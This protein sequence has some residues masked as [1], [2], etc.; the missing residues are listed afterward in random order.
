MGDFGMAVSQRGFDVKNCPDNKLLFSTQHRTLKILKEGWGNFNAVV[1]FVDGFEAD[2]E[3]EMEVIHDLGF[4]PMYFVFVLGEDGF[5]HVYYSHCT[6]T[7]LIVDFGGNM[8]LT[9]GQ[10][11]TVPLRYH[12]MIFDVDLEQSFE[13]LYGDPYVPFPPREGRRDYGVKVSAE[14]HNVDNLRENFNSLAS[15]GQSFSVHKQGNVVVSGSTPGTPFPIYIGH[16]LPYPPE[17]Y[18]YHKGRYADGGYEFVY[19]SDVDFL[20]YGTEPNM[21]YFKYSVDS[22]LLTLRPTSDEGDTYAYVILKDS[23][24]M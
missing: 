4:Y 7:K 5:E 15:Y 14:R 12:Y 2:I 21:D 9:V 13:D 16:H 11:G 23:I 10:T 8:R 22:T 3:S 19:P 1:N 18:V 17:T 20:Y 6:K 24:K